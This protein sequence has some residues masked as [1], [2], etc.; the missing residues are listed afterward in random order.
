VEQMVREQ[1]S[2]SRPADAIVGEEFGATGAGDRRWIVDPIDGTKNYA[3]GV[4]VWATLIAL[5]SEGALCIGVVSAPA[6]GARWWAERGEGAFRDGEPIR[7]SEVTRV[8][9]AFLAYDSVSALDAAGKGDQFLALAR[10]CW[11]TR[12]LGDFWQHMLV[13]DGSIDIALEVGGLAIWDTASL[14]VIVEEAGGRFTDVTG[15][16]RPD[17]GDAISTNGHLHEAVLAALAP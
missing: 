1:L 15:A 10:R 8:E 2:R 14:Q 5:E 9:D 13:A 17:K 12:G 4:P 16:P 7:V 6:L 3:R 11:R